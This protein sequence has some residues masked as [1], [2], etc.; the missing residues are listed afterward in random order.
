VTSVASPSYGYGGQSPNAQAYGG[1]PPQQ[2]QQP[3]GGGGYPPQQQ[4]GWGQPAQQQYGGQPGYGQQGYGQQQGYSQ[5]AYA[6]AQ[7]PAAPA[8]N[9][10]RR[11]PGIILLLS[12]I[13]LIAAIVVPW[14]SISSSEE[15]FTVTATLTIYGETCAS[16]NGISACQSI[17]SESSS[18]AGWF[19]ASM[20]MAFGALICGVIAGIIGLLA[21]IGR[22]KGGKIA[23]VLGIL[24]F[25][26][27]LGSPIYFY[28]GEPGG[29]SATPF[30]DLYAG[31]YLCLVGGIFALIGAILWFRAKDATP[32]AQDWSQGGHPAYQQGAYDQQA[33]AQQ[34]Y[35]QQGYGQQPGYPQQYPPQQGYPPQYGQQPPQY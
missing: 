29:T 16:G 13:L 34:G 17:F 11:V 23:G 1:Y 10:R 30:S 9:T 3:Y 21:V 28:V 2:Q 32:P 27:G 12:M 18:N 31:W 5:Q 8:K 19:Y 6:T 24:T 20:G 25:A 4:Q 15:G 26:L 14:V 33:Y 7:Q 22:N 35:A